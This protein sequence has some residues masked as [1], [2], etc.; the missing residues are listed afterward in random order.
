MFKIARTV[1]RYSAQRF[2]FRTPDATKIINAPWIRGKSAIMA[3]ELPKLVAIIISASRDIRTPKNNNTQLIMR[4]P[5]GTA[6]A[7]DGTEAF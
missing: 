5:S 6:T 4:M 3:R 2:I 1:K 7:D